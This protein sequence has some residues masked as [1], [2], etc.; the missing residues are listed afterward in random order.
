MCIWKRY[1]AEVPPRRLS[2]CAFPSLKHIRVE[3]HVRKTKCSIAVREEQ[4]GV[5]ER[6]CTGQLNRSDESQKQNSW[7]IFSHYS[8]LSYFI[9]SFQLTYISKSYFRYPRCL[10][11]D[12]VNH[13]FSCTPS[14]N[15]CTLTA[16][17]KSLPMFT[18]ELLAVL[19][20]LLIFICLPIFLSAPSGGAA[21]TKQV[22]QHASQHEQEV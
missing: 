11:W 19:I 4:E 15:S 9:Q 14:M 18:Q 22:Q 1:L 2:Q 10:F 20:V 13:A 6:N 8:L 21:N 17:L 5:F 16:N 12:L 3:M 7:L